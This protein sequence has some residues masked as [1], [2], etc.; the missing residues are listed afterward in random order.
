MY[1]RKELVNFR[2]HIR[3]NLALRKK[4]DAVAFALPQPGA[5]KQANSFGNPHKTKC[6]RH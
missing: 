2:N 5:W 1:N 6:R 3:K 4:G